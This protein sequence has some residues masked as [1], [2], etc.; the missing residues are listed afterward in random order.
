MGGRG[1]G[2]VLSCLALGCAAEGN[3]DNDS[4]STG[5]ASE[6]DAG[7]S[8][9]S[10]GAS[11][12]CATPGGGTLW[13]D[14]FGDG[15][16]WGVAIEE[17]GGVIAVGG[18]GS[19]E[20]RAWLRRYDADGCVVAEQ[21]PVADLPDAD[22]SDSRA[23]DV[24]IDSTGAFY[25]C[26]VSGSDGWLRKFAP[27][28]SV[29]WTVIDDAPEIR[30]LSLGDDWVDVVGRETGGEVA[31]QAFV[32]RYGAADGVERWRASDETRMW[33]GGVTSLPDGGTLAYGSG[34]AD[35]VAFDASGNP[36]WTWESAEEA[37][38][39]ADV[40]GAVVLGDRIVMVG[41]RS[42]SETYPNEGFVTELALDG[43]ELASTPVTE[44]ALYG[45]DVDDDGNLVLLGSATTEIG[46]DGSSELIGDLWLR[47]QGP[48]GSVVFSTT[49]DAGGDER[50]MGLSAHA[51]RIAVAGRTTASATPPQGDD[52]PWVG[53][54]AP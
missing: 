28:G 41:W 36:T 7:D 18:T 4:E 20:P 42:E 47:T 25:V 29:E 44:A 8:S 17:T 19:P 30:A 9:E 45:V 3:E 39:A 2:W 35:A 23:H 51:G 24:A 40:T 13:S 14:T 50:F 33:F 22:S 31:F 43:T 49:L 52:S 27:D 32:A 26:G 34:R 11:Q 21:Q 12:H 48:D 38:G 1:L 15:Q 5:D 54:F 37:G 53:V 16:A 10:T 46:G 6:E